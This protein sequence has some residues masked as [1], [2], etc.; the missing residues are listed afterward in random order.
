MEERLNQ[1]LDQRQQQR[2]LPLQVRYGR[3]LEM[4]GPEVEDEVRQM[5]DDNPALQQTESDIMDDGGDEFD[6]TPEQV[7]LADYPDEDETPYYQRRSDSG[8]DQSD[9]YGPEVADDTESLSEHLIGQLADLRL[10][11]R[12]LTIARYIIGNLDENGY[13]ERDTAAIAYDIEQY[14]STPLTR[15][16]VETVLDMIRRLDPPGVGARDLRECLLLQLKRRA[17]DA[18]AVINARIIVNHYFDLFS[19]KHYPQLASALSLSM[20]QLHEAVA[21]IHSLNPKPGASYSISHQ[22]QRRN[23]ILPDFSVDVEGDTL[24]VSLL[25][26]IPELSVESTFTVDAEQS[27]APQSDARLFIKQKR[28]D[29]LEFIQLLQ[30]RQS[31]LYKVM[32]AIVRLQAPFF[33]AQ[34]GD[35]SLLRP[36]ILRDVADYTGLDLSVISRAASGKYV[37]TSSGVYPLKMFFNERFRDGSA[38]SDESRSEVSTH[39]ILETIRTLVDGEDKRHPMSD[40]AITERLREAGFDMARRTVAKYRERLGLPVARLRREF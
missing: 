20:P 37:T 22:D 8:R 7:Q 16:D 17:G 23:Y 31:T 39:R 36:M 25:N 5:L 19:L 1:S 27:L 18:P 35:K 10:D 38:D 26:H 14:T 28:E 12:Q 21:V 13:L 9:A 30:M 15:Q 24:S 32:E 2:L 29:A 11:D 34:T 3:M 6:E 4:S 40:E 33:L